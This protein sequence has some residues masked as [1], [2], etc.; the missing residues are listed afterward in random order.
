MVEKTLRPSMVEQTLRPS[1]YEKSAI[2]P[3]SKSSADQGPKA[4]LKAMPKD[5]SGAVKE[6]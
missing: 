1:I 3:K 2:T 4:S 6:S 5:F